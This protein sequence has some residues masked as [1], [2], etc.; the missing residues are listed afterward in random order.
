MREARTG[1]RPSQISRLVA[2]GK[3]SFERSARVRRA[4]RSRARGPITPS[5]AYAPVTS[6]G[7]ARRLRRACHDQVRVPAQPGDGQVALEAATLVE[8]ARVDEAPRR[9]GDVVGAEPLER[10]FGVG[11]FQPELGERGL[12]EDGDGLTARAVLGRDVGE[13]VL[14]AEGVARLGGDAFGGEPVG[15]L[16]AHL[17]AEAGAP[18]AK[19]LVQRRE[20]KAPARLKLTVR[21][22]HEVVLAHDLA[23]ALPQELRAAVEGREAADVGLPQVHRRDRKSTRLNSSH[24]KISYAVFCLK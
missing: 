17:V 18:V 3:A 11:A 1:A 23:G 8:H 13:P 22:G 14:P 7:V 20:A 5:T 21:K 19:A 16:P 9:H 15:A 6:L 12:V 2:K 4:R 24:V 10:G